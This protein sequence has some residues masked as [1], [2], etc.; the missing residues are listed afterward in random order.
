[1]V[2]FVTVL[3]ESLVMHNSVKK[4]VPGIFYNQAEEDPDHDV[5]PEERER[6]ISNLGLVRFHVK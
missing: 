6:T 1:M 5:V 2:N 4:V 3:I